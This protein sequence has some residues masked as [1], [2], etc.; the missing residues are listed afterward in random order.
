MSEDT[1]V[2]QSEAQS[3]WLPEHKV[4]HS[5]HLPFAFLSKNV[6]FIWCTWTKGR[7]FVKHMGLIALYFLC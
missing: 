4:L 5:D 6:G 3:L 2:Q 7:E 1:V